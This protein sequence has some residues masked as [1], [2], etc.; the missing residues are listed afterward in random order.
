MHRNVA[1]YRLRRTLSHGSGFVKQC[2]TWQSQRIAVSVVKKRWGGWG[3]GELVDF[4][5]YH[6]SARIEK[7]ESSREITKLAMVAKTG[8][9]A[10]VLYDMS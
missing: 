3:V 8:L 6:F 7:P 1:R 5:L 9:L 4:D 10:R 2:Y